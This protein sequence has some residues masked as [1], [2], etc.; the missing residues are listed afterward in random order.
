MISYLLWYNVIMQFCWKK[1]LTHFTNLNSLGIEDNM[2][3]QHSQKPFWVYKFSEVTTFTYFLLRCQKQQQQQQTKLTKNICIVPFS[4]AKNCIPVFIFLYIFM[5]V[6][7]RETYHL[8]P[9]DVARFY[10]VRMGCG[11]NNLFKASGCLGL[12]KWFTLF[13]S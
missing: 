10:L 6:Y 9:R 1:K 12:V 13:L 4:K 5:S 3:P 11:L 7:L 2:L 8:C